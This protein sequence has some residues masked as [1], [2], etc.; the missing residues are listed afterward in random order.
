MESVGE[1]GVSEARNLNGSKPALGR[2]VT[3]PFK[4][5]SATGLFLCPGDSSTISSIGEGLVDLLRGP[6]TVGA[7]VDRRTQFCLRC[8]LLAPGL[9]FRMECFGESIVFSHLKDKSA[10][11]AFRHVFIGLCGE[12]ALPDTAR[13]AL[14]LGFSDGDPDADT[15]DEPSRRRGVLITQFRESE[16]DTRLILILST[17]MI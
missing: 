17:F 9:P 8:P 10:V 4:C 6:Q 16:D 2:S 5:F 11:D 3:S 15:L 1:L 13:K 12:P 7:R 14:D